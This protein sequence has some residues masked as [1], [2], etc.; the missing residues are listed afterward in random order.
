[1]AAQSSL[2]GA[3]PTVYGLTSVLGWLPTMMLRQTH[4]RGLM[5]GWRGQWHLGLDGGRLAARDVQDDDELYE[6]KYF[7]T[8]TWGP[9]P[10]TRGY[11]N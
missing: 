10:S 1:M 8:E 3:I 7:F 6:R 9:L 11:A 4:G 2:V 5:E